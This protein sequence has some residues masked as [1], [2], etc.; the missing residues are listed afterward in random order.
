[1]EA[2]EGYFLGA[3]YAH[4]IHAVRRVSVLTVNQTQVF[5]KN[6]IDRSIL[7]EM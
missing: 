7:V 1:M 2:A 6:C 3:N 4:V 5:K